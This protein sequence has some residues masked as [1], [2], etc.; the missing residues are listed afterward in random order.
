MSDGSFQKIKTGILNRITGKGGISPGGDSG[1]G[2][3]ETVEDNTFMDQ[4][5]K[6]HY[7][8]SGGTA[9]GA[10]N[11]TQ[12]QR[13]SDYDEQ[14]EKAGGANNNNIHTPIGAT[15]CEQHQNQTNAPTLNQP[16]PGGGDDRG[17]KQDGSS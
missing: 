7:S 16:Q 5:M 10:S 4:Y 6:N 12:T 1:G 14:G 3:G 2:G 15:R 13:E 17:D 9:G 8:Q 11:I